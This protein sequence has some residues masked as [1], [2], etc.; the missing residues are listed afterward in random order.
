[1]AQ[2]LSSWDRPTSEQAMKTQKWQLPYFVD[3]S[4][5]SKVP[6]DKIGLYSL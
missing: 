1:M 2:S 6:I 3:M 4:D 5:L